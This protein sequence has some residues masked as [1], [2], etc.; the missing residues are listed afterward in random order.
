MAA[1][2]LKAQF[3]NLL[4]N[5]RNRNMKRVSWPCQRKSACK[6]FHWWQEFL[7]GGFVWNKQ[8]VTLSEK[9]ASQRGQQSWK[10]NQVGFQRPYSAFPGSSRNF[11]FL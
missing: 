6:W 11:C 2:C 4:R 5:N 3:Q 1:A 7:Y 10:C 9:Q 8:V